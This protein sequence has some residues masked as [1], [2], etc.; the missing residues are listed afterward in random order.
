MKESLDQRKETILQ[1]VIV[2]YVTTVEPVGS[3]LLTQ[4]YELGVKAAT[5]RNELAELSDLGYIEQP[6]TSAGRIPSDLGYRYYV[7]FLVTPQSVDP[8]TRQ[9]LKEAAT[10]GEALQTLLRDTVRSLSRITQLLSVATTVRDA[11]VV[12]KNAVLSALGPSKALLVLIL[13][14]GHVEN[15]MIDCPPGLSL[16]DVGR[17]NENLSQQ[18]VGKSLRQLVRAKTP[19][20]D[21]APMD[22]LMGSVWSSLRACAKDLTRGSII[23]EGEE[24]MFGQPEFRRDANILTELLRDLTDSEIL[25]DALSQPSG[26]PQAVTIGRENR[27][28][29]MHRLSVVR[30]AFFVG[31]QEAGVIALV[32]PTRMS[33]E[34]GMPL[35]GF[36]A[37]ALSDSLT[38]YFG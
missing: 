19:S 26:Q 21:L 15:K 10:D 16:E 5:V 11:D 8:N 37:K 35:V 9:R 4:K 33:Y 14:N 23:S 7:D 17:L 30:N 2:E 13:G 3:E 12:V 34:V 38:K 36:T 29:G 1:A 20:S 6:H 22:K 28:E 24:F 32:G 18:L 27:H 31:G 25:Y